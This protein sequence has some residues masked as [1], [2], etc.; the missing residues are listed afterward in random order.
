MHS[1]ANTLLRFTAALLKHQAQ[2]RPGEEV[3]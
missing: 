3:P 1:F 2:R